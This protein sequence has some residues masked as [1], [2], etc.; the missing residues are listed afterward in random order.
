MSDEVRG[1]LLLRAEEQVE[2]RDPETGAVVERREVVSWFEDGQQI[3]N[4]A[5][6]AELEKEYQDASTEPC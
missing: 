1:G 6:C 5:R 2:V 3:M 4:A